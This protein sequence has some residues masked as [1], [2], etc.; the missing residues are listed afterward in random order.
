MTQN[1]PHLYQELFYRNT[2]DNLAKKEDFT[3]T[4]SIYKKALK[5]NPNSG[6]CYQNLAEITAQTPEKGSRA[7]AID[8]YAQAWLSNAKE[9][10]AWHDKYQLITPNKSQK[11]LT[12]KSVFVTGWAHSGTT[13]ML[14][15]LN[16]HPLLYAINYESAIFTKSDS[17]IVRI[18]QVFD[19]ICDKNDTRYW[20]EKTP[21]HIYTLGKIFAHRPQSKII[22]MLRDGRDVICSQMKSPLFKNLEYE[23]LVD[24]WIASIIAGMNFLDDSRLKLVKYEDLITQTEKTL[25]HIF[26]CLEEDYTSKILD[27]QQQPFYYMNNKKVTKPEKLEDIRHILQLRNWQVNQP[28][29]DGRGRWKKEMSEEQKEIFKQKAQKY[30]VMFSYATDDNW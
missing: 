19:E 24:Y 20:V 14:K 12:R 28:I 25:Q 3:Q 15:L 22:W 27:D 8:L 11:N 6:W 30:L 2:K 1:Y 23:T 29:F 21:E 5:L 13:L 18:L 16:N 7:K 9:V 10:K 4:I 17:E 26:L